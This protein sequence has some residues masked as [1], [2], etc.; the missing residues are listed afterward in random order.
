VTADAAQ[1]IE[2]L[3]YQLHVGVLDPV[4]DHLDEV[5]G[6][7]GADIGNTRLALGDRRDGGED[8]AERPVSFVGS[9]GHD[10]RSVQSAV[11]TARDAGAD[12]VQSP[13]FQGR[14]T[15]DRVMEVGV[16]TVDN[17]VT[18]FEQVGELIDDRVGPTARLN[19]NERSAWPGQRRHKVVNRLGGDE[20]GVS[21]LLHQPVS[22]F[23]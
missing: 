7:V 4:V 11:L 17:N 23:R 22:A 1:Q 10:R 16:A 14:L 21:M 20:S 6:A 2:R 15:A 12:K 13:L 19:H 8:R 3:R 5:A 18:V 9:A